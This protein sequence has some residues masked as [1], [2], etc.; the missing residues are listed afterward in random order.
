MHLDEYAIDNGHK[1]NINANQLLSWTWD[2]QKVTWLNIT[3]NIQNSYISAIELYDYIINIEKQAI[4]I[5]K[6]NK[7]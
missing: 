7:S 1:K 4:E 6:S 3:I 2:D 5:W